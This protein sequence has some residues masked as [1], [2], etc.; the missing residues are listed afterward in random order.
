[1]AYTYNENDND[2]TEHLP[3]GNAFNE[4][5][6]KAAISL[7]E[8]PATGATVLDAGCGPGGIIPLL[9][10][11]VGNS[12]KIV[13]IDGSTKNLDAAKRHIAK[14]H[15]ED[16]VEFHKLN[17]FG[18]LPF[19]EN[20]FD[21]VWIA[22]VILPNSVENPPDFVKHLIHALKPGG[23][24]AIYYGNWLRQFFLPGYSRLE[25]QIWAAQEINLI[26]NHTPFQRSWNGLG[27]PE[28]VLAWM[29]GAGL[30]EPRIEMLPALH[31]QPLSDDVRHFVGIEV[32]GSYMKGAIETC[33]DRVGLT[34]ED[35][36]LWKRLVEPES[37]EYLLNRPDYYCGVTAIFAMAKKP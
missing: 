12:G 34:A 7:L 36:Q 26:E 27:H 15:L 28:S 18:P 22:D 4:P 8:L 16:V 24:C 35:I 29:Q 17:L 1:M 3:F 33:G 23:T 31:R 10:A 25:H 37:A 32:F 20:T 9:Y 5:A 30:V 6:T 13:G 21:L 14:Y 19:A 2:W 11:A